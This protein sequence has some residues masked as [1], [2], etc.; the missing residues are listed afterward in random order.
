M[1]GFFIVLLFLIG[2]YS[3]GQNIL[4]TNGKA[5]RG[6]LYEYK[7]DV[8]LFITNKGDSLILNGNDY[9][10]I[11][12]RHNTVTYTY[13]DRIRVSDSYSVVETDKGIGGARRI[14][15]QLDFGMTFRNDDVTTN[16][17]PGFSGSANYLITPYSLLGA[18]VGFDDYPDMRMVPVFIKLSGAINSQRV[19][20]YYEVSTGHSYAKSKQKAEF[21]GQLKPKADGGFRLH[22]MI[23]FKVTDRVSTT[24]AFGLLHQKMST[25]TGFIDWMGNPVTTKQRRTLNMVT[26]RFG[27]IF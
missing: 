26:F 18:G 11:L 9:N 14:Y 16:V 19:T 1:R 5:I 4:R 24:F 6:K 12:R 2:G 17:I 7:D 10:I 21:D 25:T 8:I 23:G 20:P 22:P 15:G 3:Y 27:F 13:P